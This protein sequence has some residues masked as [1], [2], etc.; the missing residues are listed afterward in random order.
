MWSARRIV[1]PE[2][3]A[4]FADA[5]G[6]PAALAQNLFE[7]RLQVFRETVTF[8]RGQ[9][10]RGAREPA[11]RIAF[12]E[13]RSMSRYINAHLSPVGRVGRLRHDALALQG[14]QGLRHRAL[15]YAQIG[16]QARRRTRKAIGACQIT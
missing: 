6:P 13:R 1:R 10:R 8:R 3:P 9:R 5:K 12:Q 11:E 4:G 16:G 2:V 7:Q 15:G 14:V